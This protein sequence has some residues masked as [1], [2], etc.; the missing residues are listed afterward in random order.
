MTGYFWITEFLR[1]KRKDSQAEYKS[2]KTLHLTNTL[3]D[4]KHRH[5]AKTTQNTH[6]RFKKG[7]KVLYLKVIRAIYG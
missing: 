3:A 5:D 7:R 6:V 2:S 1:P 4:N